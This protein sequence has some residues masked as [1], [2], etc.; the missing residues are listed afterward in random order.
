LLLGEAASCP[1]L[2]DGGREC[3]ALAWHR[4]GHPRNPCREREGSPAAGLNG[5]RKR[6]VL[7]A[8]AGGFSH[9]RGGRPTGGMAGRPH[10]VARPV[11]EVLPVG[12]PGGRGFNGQGTF[13]PSALYPGSSHRSAF[14][15]GRPGCFAHP[16]QSSL[17]PSSGNRTRL[18]RDG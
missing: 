10:S 17:W 14:L 7:V 2:F 3:A 11:R 9:K 12:P 6:A 4:F 18:P 16:V 5:M 8:K 15:G 13:C 1:D